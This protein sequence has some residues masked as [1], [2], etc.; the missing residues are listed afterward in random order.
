[1]LF[2]SPAAP[3][4]PVSAPRRTD[5]PRPS[6]LTARSVFRPASGA[7]DFSKRLAESLALAESASS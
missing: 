1:M 3:K 2:R 5:E 7:Y 4:P 6:G